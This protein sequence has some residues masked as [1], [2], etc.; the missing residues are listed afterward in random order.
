MLESS[1]L[2]QFINEIMMVLYSAFS[3]YAIFNLLCNPM[4]CLLIRDAFLSCMLSHVIHLCHSFCFF[5]PS[6]PSSLSLSLTN[7]IFMS[8]FCEYFLLPVQESIFH[9]IN[10]KQ[11]IFFLLH[12]Y[13]V[14]IRIFFQI[15]FL[16]LYWY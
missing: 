5:I 11:L 2:K 9:L 4:F 15:L 12:T 10:L 16:K 8:C 3:Y 6:L 13:H 14:L 1:L 7:L